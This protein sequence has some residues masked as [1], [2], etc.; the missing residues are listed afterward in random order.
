MFADNTNMIIGPVCIF[1]IRFG[2][3]KPQTT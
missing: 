1:Q 3:S 2:L